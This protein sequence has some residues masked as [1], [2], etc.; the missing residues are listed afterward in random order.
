MILIGG[1]MLFLAFNLFLLSA[2]IFFKILGIV[3]A[4]ALIGFALSGLWWLL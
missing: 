2:R 4:I 3:I 1:I